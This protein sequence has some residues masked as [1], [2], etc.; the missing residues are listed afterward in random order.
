[1]SKLLYP[2]PLKTLLKE[3]WEA[4]KTYFRCRK[5]VDIFNFRL[6]NQQVSITDALC[7]VW[8][9]K[10]TTQVKLQC[11]LGYVLKNSITSEL[12]YFHSSANNTMLF[13]KPVTIKSLN[14]IQKIADFL[15]DLD[16]C[17]KA[18]AYRPNSSWGVLHVTNISFY[19]SKLP[20][21]KIG[22][23]C[24]IP[25]HIKKLK[26]VQ[27]LI[28][29]ANNK[30]VDDNLCFFQAFYLNSNGMCK[31]R[32]DCLFP[33]ESLPKIHDLY[34]S[35]AKHAGASAALV[36]C[37][38]GVSLDDLRTLEK[39]F[40]IKISVYSLSRRNKCTLVFQSFS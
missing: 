11:C 40:D 15:E 38:Q 25:N 30:P 13:D 23:P 24:S 28:R 22:R 21:P 3:N 31:K 14:D 20:F 16:M 27:T 10:T 34:Y 19:L 39:I 35:Y 26:C 2:T 5:V 9:N 17:V 37:F 12:R 6:I 32:C 33:K 7:D 8:L 4:V 18:K 29:G 1:M 36:S